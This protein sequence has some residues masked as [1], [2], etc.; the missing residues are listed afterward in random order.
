MEKKQNKKIYK[1]MFIILLIIAIILLVCIIKKIINS[2]NVEKE[3][4]E[5]LEVFAR[6]DFEENQKE[7]TPKVQLNG[8]D[9]IGTI[10]I[11]RINIEYPIVAIEHPNPD[12][13]KIP[14]TFSI[15]RYWGGEVN[16]YGNLSIAGHNKYD[17][18]MFGKVNKLDVGDVLSLTDLKKQTVFYKV[19]SK[20]VTDP[21]DISV[22]ENKNENEREVTLITCTDGNKKRLILKAKEII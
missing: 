18:T 12:E 2:R 1:L 5:T 9:V 7:E 21:N 20:F 17:G 11:P 13:T 15:V 4:K 3:N 6:T 16:G 14:L 19:Y 22:L 8:Y 10:K